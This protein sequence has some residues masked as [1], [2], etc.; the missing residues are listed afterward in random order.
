MNLLLKQFLI[1]IGVFLIIYWFQYQDDKKTKRIRLTFYEKYKFPL[2]ISSIIGLLLTM[3]NKIEVS[4]TTLIVA[5]SNNSCVQ[6][7]PIINKQISDQE[8]FTDLP[9]F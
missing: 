2:L 6:E 7:N 4:E 1:I 5:S 3:L 9:D 8:V